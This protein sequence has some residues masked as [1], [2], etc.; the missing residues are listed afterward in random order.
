MEPRSCKFLVFLGANVG[1]ANKYCCTP[2]M[3]AANNGHLDTVKFLHSLGAKLEHAD[4]KGWTPLVAAAAWGR[5][6]I[7][8][9][10]V[11][12]GVKVDAKAKDGRSALDVANNDE[13]KSILTAAKKKAQEGAHLMIQR[14]V[15]EALL[16][17]D[18]TCHVAAFMQLE[19]IATEKAQEEATEKAQED[20][21]EEMEKNC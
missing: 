7:V 16:P 3:V 12:Q 17:Y 19:D 14:S 21:T 2:L 1:A 6:D 15:P 4:R 10:L 8:E 13:I 5:T 11:S 18:L 9:Y 20:A